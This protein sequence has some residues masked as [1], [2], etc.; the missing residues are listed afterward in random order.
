MRATGLV[1]LDGAVHH[2]VVGEPEGRHAE[3]G[4]PRGEAAILSVRALGGDLAGAVEQ[5][6]LAVHVQVDDAPAHLAIIATGPVGI[7]PRSR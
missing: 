3:L 7:A 5:R 2:A 1:V 4:R 6:V